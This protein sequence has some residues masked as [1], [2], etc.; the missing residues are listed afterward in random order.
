MSYI[1][2]ALQRAD[3]ERDRGA[4]PG[5][6]ARQ[7][8][9]PNLTAA[10]VAKSR[11][12]LAL[13]VAVGLG[14]LA[15]G[16]W[17]GRSGTM[18]APAMDVAPQPTAVPHALPL[19]LPVSSAL[20]AVAVASEPVTTTPTAPPNGVSATIS[21]PILAVTAEKAV[22]APQA[23]P[24]ESVKEKPPVVVPW[25]ADLPEDIRR[26]VPP[27]AITGAVYSDNPAQRLLLINGQVLPQG[28]AVTPE[29]TLE[30]IGER[31]SVLS[32]RGTRFRLTH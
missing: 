11:L 30:D 32:F 14:A 29:V 9:T 8:T 20:P 16:L 17:L 26:Q 24:A 18:I 23:K 7:V 15:A 13:A 6:H 4:V 5:L 3:A 31:H 10:S 22:P 12:W 28:S 19:P 2:D 21:A 25:L 27:L 1:L